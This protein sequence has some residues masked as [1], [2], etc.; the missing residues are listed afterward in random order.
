[1][2]TTDEYLSK[3]EIQD[4]IPGIAKREGIDPHLLFAVVNQESRFNPEAESPAGAQGL[5][6]LMP[7]TQKKW[8]VSDPFDEE[9]N[10]TGSAKELKWLHGRY[11]GDITKIL[12]GYNAGPGAVD[13]HGG[14]PPYPETQRYVRDVSAEYDKRRGFAQYASANS[15][16]SLTDAMNTGVKARD[17]RNPVIDEGLRIMGAT[18][19]DFGDKFNDPN[20]VSQFYTATLGLAE[21]KND[22]LTMSMGHG[23]YLNTLKEISTQGNEPPPAPEPP[24]PST[25]TSWFQNV[26]HDVSETFTN[27]KVNLL[28]GVAAGLFVDPLVNL[29]KGQD[30]LAAWTKM[31]GQTPAPVMQGTAGMFSP[32]QEQFLYEDDLSMRGLAGKSMEEV[33]KTLVD[34]PQTGT[35]SLARG[36]A[37]MILP[38]LALKGAGMVEGALGIAGNALQSLVFTDPDSPAIIDL[39]DGMSRQVA[40][41]NS[42]EV[43]GA[44]LKYINGEITEEDLKTRFLRRGIH[45]A[46]GGIFAALIEGGLKVFRYLKGSKEAKSLLTEVQGPPVP[47]SAQV[48]QAELGAPLPAEILQ[49][50]RDVPIGELERAAGMEVPALRQA[51]AA[52]EDKGL[53]DLYSYMIQRRH[54]QGAAARGI[55]PPSTEP[56]LGPPPIPPSKAGMAYLEEQAARRASRPLP[57]T[58]EPH[59]PVWEGKGITPGAPDVVPT[60]GV[61]PVEYAAQ[62]QARI[63]SRKPPV[64]PPPPEHVPI[65]ANKGIEPGAPETVVEP[66]VV[67]ARNG[68]PFRSKGN[69]TTALNARTDLNNEAYEVVEAAAGKWVIRRKGMVPEQQPGLS[70]QQIEEIGQ[71]VQGAKEVETA[72][73]NMVEGAPPPEGMR[74][75][76]NSMLD[77]ISDDPEAKSVIAGAL[78]RGTLGAIA[79]AELTPEEASAADGEKSS[80]GSKWLGGLLGGIAFAVGGSKGAW[81]VAKKLSQGID[82]TALPTSAVRDVT[83]LAPSIRPRNFAAPMVAK[84]GD[85]IVGAM[86]RILDPEDAKRFLTETMRF[87][88]RSGAAKDQFVKNIIGNLDGAANRL[89]E[90]PRF[91]SK[92]VRNSGDMEGSA[93]RIAAATTGGRQ[94]ADEARDLAARFLAGEDTAKEM[95]HRYGLA[96]EFANALRSNESNFG[97]T[98]DMFR[99]DPSGKVGKVVFEGDA[100][101]RILPTDMSLTQFAEFV[102]KGT[103]EQVLAGARRVAME[104]TAGGALAEALMSGYLIGPR[105]PIK[106]Y[107]ANMGRLYGEVYF[108]AAAS[109]RQLLPNVPEGTPMLEDALAALSATNHS[110]TTSLKL[111]VMGT[112][113][114]ESRFMESGTA[115][116]PTHTPQFQA[117]AFMSEGMI[118]QFPRAAAVIDMFGAQMRFLSSNLHIGVSEASQFMTEQMETAFQASKAARG[119]T[120]VDE[121]AKADWILHYKDNIPPAAAAEIKYQKTALDFMNKLTDERGGFQFI[122]ELSQQIQ[123]KAAD[124]PILRAVHLPFVRSMVNILTQKAEVTPFLNTLSPAFW[125]D[126]M[127]N[128]A[129]VRTVAQG[130]LIGS[131]TIAAIG[132]GL[133]AAGNM[134]GQNVVPKDKE[135]SALLKNAGREPNTIVFPLSNGGKVSVRID[136]KDPFSAVMLGFAQFG[137]QASG[138]MTPA[139]LNGAQALLAWSGTL[140]DDTVFLGTLGRLWEG[141]HRGLDKV[142]DGIGMVETSRQGITH[143]ALETLDQILLRPMLPPVAWQQYAQTM[144]PHKLVYDTF[145]QQIAARSNL[146]NEDLK[147]QTDRFGREVLW[148]G[149]VNPSLWNQ[150]LR[151][152]FGTNP[153]EIPMDE[154]S[155]RLVDH[156]IHIKPPSP[157]MSGDHVSV[158][159][160]PSEVQAINDY[161]AQGYEMNGVKMSPLKDAVLQLLRHPEFEKLP[162]IPGGVASIAV[163]QLISQ[164]DTLARQKL[165]QSPAGEDIR[166]AGIVKAKSLGIKI[167]GVGQ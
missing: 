5:G 26:L 19:A 90:D 70:A 42:G 43:K 130:K 58:P 32:N 135:M 53:Q 94:A 125:K 65:W 127:S 150:A 51:R 131:Y 6:Q 84:M 1:M 24:K 112:A 86:S 128:D 80:K 30:D 21:Q 44:V 29:A 114:G 167:D 133:G 103:T 72:I 4:L 155:K 71:S 159:L 73:P 113:T 75:W 22:K 152:I 91:L 62:Q 54:I 89:G 13:E 18:K 12:A 47:T 45:A 151:Y 149:G 138:E 158:S 117:R 110:F 129:N 67:Y 132:A 74:K 83:P 64:A 16:V 9:Q 105:S 59:V 63:A 2:P 106:S 20:F 39:I 38:F 56:I 124:T 23:A 66:A 119:Q 99:A 49:R 87:M 35:V 46:E 77:Q 157:V 161:N 141:M 136:P 107:F 126:L 15:E 120:F 153:E 33:V 57:T 17:P 121:A 52:T 109:A 79:G 100:M 85:N 41:N 95:L 148:G 98:L 34:A 147:H 55:E 50:F 101:G 68:M 144:E 97:R 61:D 104:P 163:H 93:Y 118:D 14:V 11:K 139:E 82:T 162:K 76:I 96:G 8:Q 166:K 92:F 140:I 154:L 60:G 108:H 137:A 36:L 3:Q 156:G 142:R 27:Q 115:L 146:F 164:Y 145:W 10:L 111:G 143:Q 78:T 28:G 88:P 116:L 37:S 81:W 7:A 123:D 69:A 160:L 40:P 25:Q 134:I 102:S 31:K 122:R 48:A 165:M